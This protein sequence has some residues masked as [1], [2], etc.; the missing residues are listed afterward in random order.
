MTQSTLLLFALLSITL[1]ACG[2]ESTAKK[3][4]D[5]SSGQ[6]LGMDMPQRMDMTPDQRTD[7]STTADQSSMTDMEDM[8]SDLVDMPPVNKMRCAP[9]PAPSGTIVMVTPAQADELPNIVA[10]ATEGT[11]ILLADGTYKNTK[12]GEGSRRLNFRTPNVTLRS[13]S[14]DAS[15]VILDGEYN[16]KEIINIS[17]DNVTIAH[18]TITRAEDHLIHATGNGPNHITNTKLYGLR[19]IDAGEQFVKVNGSGSGGFVD[20]GLLAC[21]YFELTDAG[22]PNIERVGGGCYTGGIDTHSAKGWHVVDNTFKDIYCAGEGLAEHAIHF[23][24]NS[25]DTLVERNV[26]EN[27]ARGIGFGLN[28]ALDKRT[29]ADNPYPN[30]GLIEHID[31]VIRNNT[32]FANIPYYDTGIE[33]QHAHGARVEHNT[34]VST[35]S[36]TGFYSS[37]DYRFEVTQVTIHNNIARRITSRNGGKADLKNNIEAPPASMFTD[38]E[39]GDLHLSPNAQQAIDKATFIEEV[40]DDFEGQ[41]RPAN[42]DIGADER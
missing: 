9:L 25:R 31:G 21:S 27:C 2:G 29:Y 26:I 14:G 13:A 24:R 18:L 3:N 16:T 12:S 4:M 41:P 1:I 40:K 8:T 39:N 32:I 15:A 17:A 22:R 6:D 5:M 42:R 11:T 37:I 19:L 38:L 33:L 35:A 36:A 23:W 34:V 28:P 20:D 30:V 10:Q 7:Q